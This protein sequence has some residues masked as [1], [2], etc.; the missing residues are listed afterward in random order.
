ME[1]VKMLERAGLD[2]ECHEEIAA[3]RKAMQS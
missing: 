1:L 2:G 3:I